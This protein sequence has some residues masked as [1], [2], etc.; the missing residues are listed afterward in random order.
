[1]RDHSI[2]FAKKWNC[3]R[4]EQINGSGGPPSGKIAVKFLQF[5]TP[6][7][8]LLLANLKGFGK[9]AN[10]TEGLCCRANPRQI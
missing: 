5:S 7:T 4:L 9:V 6:W 1:V 3:M 2:R 8:G 10:R